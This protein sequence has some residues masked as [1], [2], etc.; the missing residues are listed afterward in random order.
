MFTDIRVNG[1]LKSLSLP[2]QLLTKAYKKDCNI[3]YV[4]CAILKKD[5]KMSY[6][7]FK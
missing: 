4:H 6:Y 5:Q 7:R 3:V 2:W 1:F